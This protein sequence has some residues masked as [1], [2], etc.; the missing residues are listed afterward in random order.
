MS[1]D[2]RGFLQEM[3]ARGGGELIRVK[4]EIARDFEMAALVARL[5]AERRV[6]VLL[7]EKVRGAD[8]PA[9]VNCFA[10]RSRIAASLGLPAGELLPRFQ[11]AADRPIPPKVAASA[12]AQEVVIEG[13]AVDLTRL[14]LMRYHDT[15]AAPYLTAGIVLAKDPESGAYNLSFNRMMLKGRDRFGIFMTVGK[16]LHEIYSRREELGEA[17]PIA[18]S[19]GNHPAWALGALYIGPY[20]VDELGVIGGLMK[21]PLEMVPAKTVDLLV[22]ARAEIV[23]EGEILPFERETEGSFAE[24]HGYATKPKERQVVRV[25]A[26]THRRGA[27]YQ[28]IL[29]GPHREHLVLPTLPMEANLERAVR[30]AVPSMAALRIAAPFTLIVSIQK[31]YPGQPKSAMLAAFGAELYLKQVIVVDEDI[32]VNDF[33]RVLWAVATRCQWSRDAFVI[34]DA[35]GSSL[36]PSAATEGLV[37][38]VGIDATAKPTL[39][40]FSPRGKIPPEVMKRIRLEDYIS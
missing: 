33:S 30:A 38:K 15:D 31:R 2:L 40:S 4:R 22:P 36:D 7:F 32:D 13:E 11:E 1:E 23:L 39:D 3:E 10:S 5:E 8:F 18:V 24:F 37:D 6:P 26:V 20:Q 28:D 17:L 16:H 21:R 14:P 19:L 27:I 12:P 9:V 34:P 25:K 35:P 29:G